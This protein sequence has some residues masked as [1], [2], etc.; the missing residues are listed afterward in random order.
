[1]GRS[2]PSERKLVT[3]RAHARYIASG[4][5]FTENERPSNKSEE[6]A[7]LAQKR[8]LVQG[9]EDARPAQQRTL[10]QKVDTQRR[11]LVQRA[12]DARPA[13]T[14]VQKWDVR[15]QKRAL[16]QEEEDARPRSSR[17][18]TLVHKRTRDSIIGLSL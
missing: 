14:L 18:W 2:L 3:W 7:R 12:E 15:L 16:V 8:T 1:M 17:N 11:T 4:R 10:V 6:N 13:R 5:S 9:A